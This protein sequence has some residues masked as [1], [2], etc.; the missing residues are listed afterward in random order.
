MKQQILFLLALTV[1]SS[2]AFGAMNGLHATVEVK[3]NAIAMSG[4]SA[5]SSEEAMALILDEAKNMSSEKVL[6]AIGEPCKDSNSLKVEKSAVD[7]KK[8]TALVG[9]NF[10]YIQGVL[11]IKYVCN[12]MLRPD[13]VR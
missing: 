9:N 11:T 5:V 7:Y 13:L 1:S 6:Q 2:L 3:T 12:E 4:P 8:F 10:T